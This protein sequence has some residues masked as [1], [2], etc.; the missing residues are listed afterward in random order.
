MRPFLPE[1]K[2]RK[3]VSFMISPKTHEILE[4]MFEAYKDKVFRRFTK[5]DIFEMGIKHLAQDLKKKTMQELYQA[6]IDK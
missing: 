4:T 2:K 6:Y 1:E 5:T 3:M